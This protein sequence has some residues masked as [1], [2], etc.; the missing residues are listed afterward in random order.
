MNLSTFAR[1]E[2]DAIVTF[3]DAVITRDEVLLCLQTF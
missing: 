3:N 2:H 1:R